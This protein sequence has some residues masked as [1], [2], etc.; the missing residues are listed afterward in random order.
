MISSPT[1]KCGQITRSSDGAGLREYEFRYGVLGRALAVLTRP[2]FASACRQMLD[3]YERAL[4][5]CR[6]AR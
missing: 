6:L 3:S 1:R 4:V 2:A 5:Q